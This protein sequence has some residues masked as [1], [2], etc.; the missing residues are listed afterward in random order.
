MSADREL[1][2]PPPGMPTLLSF[3]PTRWSYPARAGIV[4]ASE[5]SAF[6]QANGGRPARLSRPRK[7]R[8]TRNVT[9]CGSREL[10]HCAWP[11]TTQARARAHT[12]KRIHMHTRAGAKAAGRVKGGTCCTHG[13]LISLDCFSGPRD[14]DARTSPRRSPE[15]PPRSLF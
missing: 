4:I 3:I 11:H 6:I 2:P 8:E 9:R 13:I 14:R 10:G 5:P 7:E 15:P 12:H 1:C